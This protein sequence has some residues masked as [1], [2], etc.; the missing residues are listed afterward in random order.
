[1][2]AA[3]KHTATHAHADAAEDATGLRH[4]LV[5]GELF[6][7]SGGSPEHNQLAANILGELHGQLKGRPCRAVGS[8]QKV[9]VHSHHAD[10]GL[11]PDVAVYC[12]P[13]QRSSASARA[14]TNPTVVFEVLSPSTE[15]YD[16]GRKFEL[17]REL[18]SLKHY[19]MLAQTQAKVE[20]YDRNPDATWTLRLVQGGQSFSLGAIAVELVVDDLYEDVFDDGADASTS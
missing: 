3:L 8:D 6:A 5:D 11:Y 17:Y 10:A 1:M 7:M 2:T 19:V 15:G 12:G 18:P 9:H 4:E 20:V 16:R 13:R 14:L